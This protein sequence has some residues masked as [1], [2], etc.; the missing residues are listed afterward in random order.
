VSPP[1]VHLIET[2]NPNVIAFEVNGRIRR[3]DMRRLIA[4]SD[5]ALNSHER[6]RILVRVVDFD[7]IALDALREDGLASIKMRGWKQV[8]RY[9]LVGGPGW[10]QTVASWSAPLDRTETRHFDR[11]QED[12]AWYWLEAEPR[13][14]S[15]M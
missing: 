5:K 11:D 14:E 10:M 8:E 12:Q 4:A 13:A 7:G 1:S 9:A 15:M 2:T 6:L 3:E